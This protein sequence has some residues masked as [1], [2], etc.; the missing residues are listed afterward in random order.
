[1]ILYGMPLYYVSTSPSKSPRYA[2]IKYQ[3]L[4]WKLNFHIETTK[5]TK[6]YLNRYCF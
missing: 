4:G 5:K 6:L 1:M 2:Q 3:T